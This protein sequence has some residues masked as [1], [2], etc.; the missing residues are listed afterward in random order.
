MLLDLEVYCISQF[1]TYHLTGDIHA[2]SAANNLL[3][4]AIDARI[5]HERNYGDRFK[6]VTG[7]DPLN[8]NP[9]TITWNRVID[10]NDRALRSAII[11]LGEKVD[12][13][14][15]QVGFDISVAS[16]V[17]AILALTTGVKD[18]RQ[19]LGRIVIGQ[20]WAGEPVTAEE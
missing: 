16:E 10:M 17:M 12:G 6:T 18:M 14:P 1:Q 13:L 15:R 19:R 5:M 9:Y 11:G 4:A 3:A 8:I 2:V 20:N 7:L